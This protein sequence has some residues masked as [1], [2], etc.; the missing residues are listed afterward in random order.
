MHKLILIREYF[1]CSAIGKT[2]FA[3]HTKPTEEATQ[4]FTSFMWDNLEY[5]E[6]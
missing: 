2:G 4:V 6:F 3:S 1:E 5:L